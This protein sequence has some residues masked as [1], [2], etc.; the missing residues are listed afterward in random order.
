MRIINSDAYVKSL[1]EGNKVKENIYQLLLNEPL[2]R[3]VCAERLSLTKNQF[4]HYIEYL[5][6]NKHVKFKTGECKTYG[7][8]LV[9]ILY[10]NL[11][12]PFVAQS[13]DEIKAERTAE[14]NRQKII[15]PHVRVYNL[16]DRKEH[17]HVKLSDN[18]H[19]PNLQSSFGM[20]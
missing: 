16:L 5:I 20:L 13:F 18:N 1:A 8:K 15:S 6:K 12:H 7:N 2:S 9:H 3:R 10:A 17:N 11:T 14:I 19:R 4:K